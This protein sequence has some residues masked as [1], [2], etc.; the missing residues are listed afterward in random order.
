M[1]PRATIW[2]KPAHSPVELDLPSSRAAACSTR[3]RLHHLRR[4]HHDGWPLSSKCRPASL[5]AGTAAQGIRELGI[6]IRHLKQH[7]FMAGLASRSSGA[8][9]EG[10]VGGARAAAQ[11]EGSAHWRI[12]KL[13]RM[14]A[15]GVV[16]LLLYD[17]LHSTKY[18]QEFYRPSNRQKSWNQPRKQRSIQT[19]L[20]IL[21]R[22]SWLMQG[23][24][25]SSA[26]FL[27]RQLEANGFEMASRCVQVCK[28]NRAH[29]Q[30]EHIIR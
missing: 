25:A 19:K 28:Q 21:R 5:P 14:V 7:Q 24:R 12:C 29:T 8:T 3:L 15:F 2:R 11:P 13:L 6:L 26:A 23:H 30:R 4:W 22:H 17:T 9:V 16:V 27:K 20:N 10:V 1:R 18:Y